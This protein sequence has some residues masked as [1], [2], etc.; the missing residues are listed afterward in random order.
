MK[1]IRATIIYN[2]VS[3][4]NLFRERKVRK[5]IRLLQARG[6]EADV[7][8]TYGPNTGANLAREAVANGSEVIVCHGGDGTL[9]EVLQGIAGTGAKLA[10]WAGG[11]ANVAAGELNM[12]H[13]LN[14]IADVIARGKTM[15]VCVGIAKNSERSRY[16]LMFAG[17]GLDASICRGV[18]PR[19]KRLTGQI[20]FWVSGI[21]HF[22]AWRENRFSITIDG[23]CYESGFS[24]VANGKGY[25]GGIRMA[26]GARLDEAA[27][28][29]FMM[30]KGAG[31]LGYL[32]ALLNIVLGRTDRTGGRLVSGRNVV[33]EGSAETW[34]QVDGEPIGTLPMSFNIIPE[35]L[36][37][38]VP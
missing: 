4:R 7:A 31:R 32:R 3:G 25:G 12:P 19:L 20:A 14:R 16:F 5:M 35:T 33:A 6:L 34:V 23:H 1:S 17:I 10:V 2:P 27:F 30:P 15:Q 24:L 38:I 18:V 37:V 36:S 22:L 8:P 29:V 13:G 28:Q 11:T 9:N 26:P 21:K